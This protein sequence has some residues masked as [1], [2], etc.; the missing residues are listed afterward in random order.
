[1]W[2]WSSLQRRLFSAV[3]LL[4][5]LNKS[6]PALRVTQSS[7]ALQPCRPQAWDGIMAPEL[8]PTAFALEPEDRQQTQHASRTR[9]APGIDLRTSSP[10]RRCHMPELGSFWRPTLVPVMEQDPN[11]VIFSGTILVP[12]L[13]PLARGMR[14]H[15]IPSHSR[16]TDIAIRF[17]AFWFHRIG[18]GLPVFSF[19]A[20]TSLPY[21]VQNT[22][23]NC[24]LKHWVNSSIYSANDVD[25]YPWCQAQ[26]LFSRSIISQTLQH[27]IPFSKQYGS[28][29]TFVCTPAIANLGSTRASTYLRCSR[30]HAQASRESVSSLL[31]A[32]LPPTRERSGRTD[33]PDDGQRLH[34][35]PSLWPVMSVYFT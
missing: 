25:Y 8:T 7:L 3:D 2:F 15:T 22:R 34:C 13:Y 20:I 12:A 35:S 27:L 17:S 29:D 33:M 5:G 10:H 32:P 18:P 9:Y 28:R 21:L 26:V 11:R 24:T 19:F 14:I 4:P 23:T 1:M 16:L 6:S 30:R 31:R